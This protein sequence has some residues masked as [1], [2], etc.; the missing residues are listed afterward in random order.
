MRPVA[1]PGVTTRGP[2]F[3]LRCLFWW[4]VI[5]AGL[6]IL[7]Y[8]LVFVNGGLLHLAYP[9]NTILFLPSLRFG[10]FT[11]FY[12]QC[13]H[14][15]TPQFWAHDRGALNYPAPAVY[16]LL[17]FF[18]MFPHHP[19]VAA[20]A[21]DLTVAG[22][23]LLAALRLAW[24]ARRSTLSGPLA[25]VL[26][27][28]LV[29]SYPLMF[30][31]DRANV[32]GAAWLAAILGTWAFVRGSHSIAAVCFAGA[33]AIKLAPLVLIFLLL[34]RRDWK[35]AALFV[36]AF[37]ALNVVAMWFLAPNFIST[38]RHIVH[39]ISSFQG[40][41]F[42]VFPRG[43]G[44]DHSF[45]GLIKQPLWWIDYLSGAA[46][47]WQR[48]VSMVCQLVYRFAWV[49]AAGFLILRFRRLPMLN[50]LFAVFIV[51]MAALPESYDYTLLYLYIPWAVFI[52]LYLGQE[53]YARRATLPLAKVL[54]ILI[55]CAIAFTPQQ[56]YLVLP[57]GI[58]FAGQIKALALLYLLIMTARV[59]LPCQAFAEPP[60]PGAAPV[61]AP[62]SAV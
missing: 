2:E 31:A 16:V 18:R 61:S 5:L 1:S 60:E 57:H 21:Y 46:P 3:V 56:C 59:P 53:V 44:V 13:A 29:T 50:C 9:Y 12:R 34:R 20:G 48:T 25:A 62:G 33:A 14:F 37:L 40:R 6:S 7:A 23:A 55:P 30:M 32:E 43:I 11:T 36:A 45:F 35:N 49:V 17:P 52:V 27:L 19:R 28:T 38:L 26:A 24:S 4:T 41:F 47:A 8:L 58:S 22:L 15:G 42:V 39:G 51:Q 10:D 54:A